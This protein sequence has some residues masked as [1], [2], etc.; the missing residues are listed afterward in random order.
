MR[1]KDFPS[2]SYFGLLVWNC[3]CLTKWCSH[4][5]LLIH[6]HHSRHYVL[7]RSR[8]G[9]MQTMSVFWN[10]IAKANSCFQPWSNSECNPFFSP[11]TEVWVNRFNVDCRYARAK[12][13]LMMFG[14]LC[15]SAEPPITTKWP[16]PLT[17]I[18]WCSD[19][20][21]WIGQ[22]SWLY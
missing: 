19:P 18:G 21:A 10:D 22:Q 5:P 12:L 7:Q 16:P 4:S 8:V 17:A 20:A 11:N 3:W 9:G 13:C 1:L 2:H 14:S 15:A 6:T